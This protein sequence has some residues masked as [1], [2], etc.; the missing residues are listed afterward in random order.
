MQPRRSAWMKRLTMRSS[1]EWYDSTASRPS[2]ASV[3]TR[4]S[5]RNGERLELAVD[6]D[7]KCLEDT[8]GR[9]H[10]AAPARRRGRRAR[11]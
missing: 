2:V 5:Q 1:S 10:A 7:P 9:V 11:D 4:T 3:S 8:R 6:G